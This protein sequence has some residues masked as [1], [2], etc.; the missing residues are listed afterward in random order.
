MAHK[1]LPLQFLDNMR[2]LFNEYNMT[3]EFDSFICSFS[4]EPVRGI[5]MNS[6]KMQDGNEFEE[7]LKQMY[8][9]SGISGS[10]EKVRWSDDGYYIPADFSPG[11][12]L[13]YLA[14][15]FYIQE[16][17]AMLPANVLDA[18][19]GDHILDIC[20]APGGK[21]VKI[22]A[23]MKGE[24]ILFS[25]DINETRTKALVRNI[26]LAGCTNCVVLNESPENLSRHMAG[27]FDKIL[28]DAPCSGEGMFR[29]D[30][31]AADSWED[32]GND[33]CVKMQ[34]DI[35][36]NVDRLLKPGG[37]I[38][39]S[40]CTFSVKENEELIEWFIAQ[41]PWYEIV[42]LAK[43]Q[44]MDPGLSD[45]ESLCGAIRIF[46]H[47]A[48]GEGHFC[49]KIRKKTEPEI[50]SDSAVKMISDSIMKSGKMKS[51][52]S[53][54]SHQRNKYP[55][56]T[57][58][59]FFN[60]FKLFSD[61]VLTSDCQDAIIKSCFVYLNIIGGH[62]YTLPEPIP[63]LEGLKIAKK[64]LYLGELKKAK[65]KIIFEPSHSFL[66]SLNKNDLRD[67]VS[68]KN[69]DPML[70][71]YFKGETIFYPRIIPGR[72]IPICIQGYPVGWGKGMHGDMIKNLYPK[73]WRKQRD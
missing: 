30:P 21:S 33:S 20:A 29:R 2:K 63:S 46:P 45:N 54:A 10:I 62:V 8:S 65:D 60:A 64:G 38:V 7:I 11:K 25:N 35:L 40:T 72:Y 3:E 42:P 47:H 12:H 4:E 6:L 68:F 9:D 27:Y 61:K 71:K 67:P 70:L 55:E 17:S 56:F 52:N 51:G 22:A 53:M 13:L 26:E 23:D 34:K 37:I 5:R 32:F 39:Y 50:I 31:A 73:G 59:D 48:R 69:D 43:P 36:A 24:G 16:P 1:N 15:L 44:N 41:H 57:A 14:G 18:K 49:I 66:L 19:P 58:D 28:V